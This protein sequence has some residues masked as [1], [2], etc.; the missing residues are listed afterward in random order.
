[1]FKCSNKFDKFIECTERNCSLNKTLPPVILTC[2]QLITQERNCQ[3]LLKS[4]NHD[5]G[6]DLLIGPTGTFYDNGKRNFY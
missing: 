6:F 3:S 2:S 1:M 4:A 5:A